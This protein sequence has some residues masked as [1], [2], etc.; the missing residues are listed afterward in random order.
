MARENHHP[1]LRSE[2]GGKPSHKYPLNK[3][4]VNV[5]LRESGRSRV[6]GKK[7][8]TGLAEGKGH[9]AV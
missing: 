9:S 7:L 2:K 3:A 1:A 6:P 4:L 8:P 5:M